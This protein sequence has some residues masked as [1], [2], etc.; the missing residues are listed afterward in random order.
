MIRR[1][2]APLFAALLALAGTAVATAPAASADA[3]VGT[4]G[5][6]VVVQSDAGTVIS[7][8]PGD[9][10]SGFDALSRAGFG[11]DVVQRFPGALCRINGYPADQA[12]VMMPP[13]T[14]YWAYW[15][16]PAGGSWTYSSAGAG[17]TNPAPGSVEGW[18]FGSGQAPSVAPPFIAPATVTPQP[19]AA[20][21]G[22]G[23]SGGGSGGTTGGTGTTT[24]GAAAGGSPA[25]AGAGDPATVGGSASASSAS[26]S[27][28]A[29][30]TTSAAPSSSASASVLATRN[31]ASR[32]DGA[33][34]AAG[35]TMTS[36]LPV[37]LG[38]LLV[39]TLAATAGLITRRRRA[40]VEQQP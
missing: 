33:A 27:G 35:A 22:G 11:F 36:W 26:P 8:A 32:S 7:C 6:T 28:S 14:A 4:S 12:C 34:G 37:V 9:P 29:A 18:R 16:A 17:S 24:G 5:V 19:P 20:T 1:L 21:Q 3:C 15:Q 13:A 38:A 25:T 39:V 40:E 10:S 23:G 30:P 31:V 2:A